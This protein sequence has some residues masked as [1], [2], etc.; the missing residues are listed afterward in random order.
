M[1][2]ARLAALAV[3]ALAP[4]W[5][6]ALGAGAPADLPQLRVQLHVAWVLAATAWIPQLWLVEPA[7][8]TVKPVA[9]AVCAIVL[10]LVAGGVP[11][12]VLLVL[13][14]WTAPEGS[15]EASAAA[16]RAHWKPVA[17]CMAGMLLVDLAIPAI[18]QLALVHVPSKKPPA[19]A[20]ATSRTALRATAA[21]LVVISPIAASVLARFRKR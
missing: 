4:W 21:A 19:S 6:I 2:Y 16:V 9:L 3:L 7:L 8:R 17:L 15:P 13:L 12:L 1:K 11:G 14:A 10:G 5:L 20:L 18:T